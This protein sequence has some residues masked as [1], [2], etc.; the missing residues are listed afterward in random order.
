MGCEFGREVTFCDSEENYQ[1][2]MRQLSEWNNSFDLES[3]LDEPKCAV[4]GQPA[5][6]RC[7]R[8]KNEWY[9][10]RECQVQAWEGHKTVCDIV[11]KDRELYGE[12]DYGI[13]N[14]L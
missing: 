12:K 9:C 3:C 13:L 7:S 8:C 4:C 11:C 2:E 6:K 10:S 14:G 5:E 1:E